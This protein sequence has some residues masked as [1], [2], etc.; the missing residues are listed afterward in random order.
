[1][2]YDTPEVIDSALKLAYGTIVTHKQ[3]CY[4]ISFAFLARLGYNLY[5]AL[6]IQAGAFSVFWPWWPAILPGP[7]FRSSPC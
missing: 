3:G 2:P 1:M 5:R 4:K 6:A 7:V